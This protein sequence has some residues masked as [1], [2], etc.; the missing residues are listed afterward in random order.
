[1]FANPFGDGTN[2]LGG[3]CGAICITT[4]ILAV[5]GTVLADVRANLPL[6]WASGLISCPVISVF[7]GDAK[8]IKGISWVSGR[9]FV[10]MLALNH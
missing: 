10:L 3:S 2:P 7:C 4:T 9:L 5:A 6:A 1:M 8:K